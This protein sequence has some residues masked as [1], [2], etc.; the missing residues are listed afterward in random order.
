M[1]EFLTALALFVPSPDTLKVASK[2]KNLL[3]Q[4][5]H[6]T[7]EQ[8]ARI[9]SPNIVLMESSQ[10][11]GLCGMVLHEEQLLVVFTS[12]KYDPR[13]Y[14]TKLI[15]TFAHEYLHLAGIHGHTENIKDDPIEILLQKCIEPY[16]VGSLY[17]QR[18]IY[19]Q[20]AQFK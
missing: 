11:V 19:S 7:A 16:I 18:W 13:C 2:A 17:D 1:I 3:M 8:K 6:V 10:E 12:A 5:E 9:D 20:R 15:G 14:D 4:C